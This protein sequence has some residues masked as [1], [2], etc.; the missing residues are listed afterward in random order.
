[1]KILGNR[2]L[3]EI[4]KN[5]REQLSVGG[6]I[7]PDRYREKPCEGV[8]REIGNGD[9]A[10]KPAMQLLEEVKAGQTVRVDPNMGSVDV[11]TNGE[12]LRIYSI[13]DVLGIVT[14]E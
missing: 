1:M 4:T 8:I 3:I 7:I 13:R 10:D 11:S 5:Q 9:A 14:D 12:L 2:V 6:I